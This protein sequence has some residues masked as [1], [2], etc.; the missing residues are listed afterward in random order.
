MKKYPGRPDRRHRLWLRQR[1]EG[2]R[3]HGRADDQV[4]RPRR[5]LRADLPRP[6]RGRARARVGEQGPRRRSRSPGNC[7]PSIT[8][9]YMLDGTIGGFYLWDPIKLGYVTYYAAKHFAEG[10]ITGQARRLFTIEKGKW[11]G[12][13]TIGETARSSPASRCSSPRRTTRT[14]TSD[15]SPRARDRPSRR[16]RTDR[17]PD[18]R[19]RPLRRDCLRSS[20]C[21][22][23]PSGSG[24]SRC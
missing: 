2:F 17:E 22:A 18:A 20:N 8:S 24:R 3:R 15:G 11:P 1:A 16:A 5:H 23:S 9:K 7:V 19:L 4:S 14:T 21:G 13:Y 10:K 6:A 12:T